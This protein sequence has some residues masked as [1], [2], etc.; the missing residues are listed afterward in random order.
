MFQK[1]I[2][3]NCGH[4]GFA[5]KTTRGS[6]LIEFLLW[7]LFIPALVYSYFLFLPGLIYSAWRLSTRRRACTKCLSTAVIPVDT[8]RGQ[9][10]ITE[11]KVDP[12]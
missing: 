6:L 2:C 10:L 5:C 11:F 8:P 7:L 3:P 12:W 1:Y 9:Q 4:Y